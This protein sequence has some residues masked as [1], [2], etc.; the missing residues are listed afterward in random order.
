MNPLKW[1][2]KQFLPLDP[3]NK[4]GLGPFRLP[5][6]CAWMEPIFAYHDKY[7]VE[8]PAL[9][10]RLSDIDC[11]IFYALVANVR[12]SDLDPIVKCNRI[13]DICKFW[14]IMHTAGPYLYGRQYDGQ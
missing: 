5:E 4:A 14:Y 11:R 2:L 3:S 8:G 10:M 6:R 12:Q 9:G 13:E 7:Y 1:I